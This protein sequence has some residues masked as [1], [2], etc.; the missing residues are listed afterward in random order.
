MASAAADIAQSLRD[1]TGTWPASAKGQTGPQQQAPGAKGAPPMYAGSTQ[2]PPPFTLEQ[3]SWLR[4][5]VADTMGVAL[6]RFCGHIDVELTTLREGVAAAQFEAAEAASQASSA[7]QGT[8]AQAEQ[9]E[10]LAKWVAQLE[11]RSQQ[12]ASEVASSALSSIPYEQ[13]QLA[14]IG[15]VGWNSEPQVLVQPRSF[16]RPQG[17]TVALGRGWPL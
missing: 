8:Q 9:L 7:K 4:G 10:A 14:I 2:G 12:A 16:W 11:D 17:W 15:N 13:R 3:G 6:E 1:M 5:A